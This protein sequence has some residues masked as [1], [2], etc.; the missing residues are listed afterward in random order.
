MTQYAFDE[1]R[2]ALMA[3]WETGDGQLAR[4][5]AVLPPVLDQEAALRLSAS[6][7]TLSR[8]AWRTYTHPASAAESVEPNTEGWRRQGERDAFAEVL[9][10]VS[11]PHLPDEQGSLVQSYVLVE[12]AAHRVGRAL[13]SFGDQ[14]LQ[15]AVIAEVQEELAAVEH[16]ELGD[17]SGRARQA[18]RLSRADASPLQVNAAH[19][20][21]HA[22]P[23][24]S[25]RLFDE[26]DPTAAAVA[27]AHWLQVAAGIA[28]DASGV[29]PASVVIEADNIESLALETPTLVLERLV[30]GE[31][32]RRV[33]VDLVAGAMT[34]AE[35]KLPDPDG[36]VHAI[37]EARTK[38]EL[39]GPGDEE[40]LAGL[41]PRVT[42]LDPARPAQDL[43]E[44]LLDGIRGCWL[45][46][47]EYADYDDLDDE[48]SGNRVDEEFFEALREQA[49]DGRDRLL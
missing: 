16:A 36:L 19:D 14:A 17:F 15:D 28:S 9:D 23:L 24:W 5:V 32:P 35:G 18:V 30:A 27:A 37:E 38:A 8:W 45:L 26:V 47:R 6:L 46:Y 22:H 43:L 20:F 41:M 34:V 13:H 3:V 31:S 49:E 2:H 25:G 42:P 11:K 1:T 12:E 40:L 10:H 48:E 29:A 33:V 44:D 39:F 4:T 21:L 7:T